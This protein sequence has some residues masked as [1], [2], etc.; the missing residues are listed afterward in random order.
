MPESVSVLCLAGRAVPALRL[1]GLEGELALC[2]A[3]LVALEA[4]AL[5]GLC[6][7]GGEV[8]CWLSLCLAGEVGWW[9]P[10]CLEGLAAVGWWLPLCLEGLAAVGRW[11]P[12]CLEGLAA[13][14]TLCRAQ[15]LVLSLMQTSTLAQQQSATVTKKHAS[16]VQITMPGFLFCRI[17]HK[18][19]HTVRLVHVAV[20]SPW[21]C[22]VELLTHVLL[23]WILGDRLARCALSLLLDCFILLALL[24]LVEDLWAGNAGRVRQTL[25]R[26]SSFQV[27]C[28]NRSRTVCHLGMEYRNLGCV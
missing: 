16:L 10:L 14:A 11:L 28:G 25:H 24:L 18:L 20:G 1:V 12:L 3:W 7:V 15:G 19:S 21:R 23:A 26:T 5:V 4:V 27:G 6:L 17:M 8:A 13:A 2:L 9:L 22:V